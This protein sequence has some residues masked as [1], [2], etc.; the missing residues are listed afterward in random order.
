MW[1]EDVAARVS[2]CQFNILRD[3]CFSTIHRLVLQWARPVAFQQHSSCFS[4]IC[5]NDSCS[6]LREQMQVGKTSCFSATFKL[7]FE[8]FVKM[9]LVH[10][11]QQF[12]KMILVHTLSPESL[13]LGG[14]CAVDQ[15]LCAV[16]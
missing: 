3:G 12:V 9:I 16:I 1:V 7:L 8:Q 2:E 13:G 5:N 15:A 6:F 4:A 10:S 11:F 14:N